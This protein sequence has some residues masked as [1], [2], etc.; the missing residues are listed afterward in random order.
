MKDM[1]GFPNCKPT[2]KLSALIKKNWRQAHTANTQ[3]QTETQ[4]SAFLFL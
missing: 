1:E 3:D 4:R 2:Y